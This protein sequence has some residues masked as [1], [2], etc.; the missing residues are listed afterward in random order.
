ATR[1]EGK[2]ELAHVADDRTRNYYFRIRSTVDPQALRP[3]LEPKEQHALD[4]IELSAPPV[5]DAEIWG[6]WHERNLTRIKAQVAI[7][8][9]FSFRGEP[10]TGFHTALEY[11]N[12][13]VQL[14]SPRLDRGAE[15]LSASTVGLDFNNRIVQVTNGFSTTDPAVVTRAVGPKVAKVME[16]YQFRQPPKVRVNGIFPMDNTA[17]ADAHF[18]VDGGPFHWEKFNLSRLSGQ[19]HWVGEHL[20]LE[21]VQAGFYQGKLTGLARFDFS[22]ANGTDFKFD[23]VVE[24]ASLHFLIADLFTPTNNLE[25]LLKGHLSVTNANTRDLHSW[26]GQGGVN[27]HDGFIWGIPVFGIFSP[28]LDSIV[29]GLGKSRASEASAAFI[30]TNGVVRSDD[31]QITAPALRIQYKGTVDLDGGKVD[32]RVTAAP[33]P[34][35][36]LVGPV[37]TV[38]LWPVSKLFEY[39]ITGTLARP[40]EEQMFFISRLLLAPFQMPFHP[41][42][43]LKGLVSGG[44]PEISTS[45]NSIAP[46]KPAP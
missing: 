33:L 45:T 20:S 21:G 1:P 25:G 36:L 32:A 7:T 17:K 35:T 8:T 15:F 19:A 2:I 23:A 13:F 24:D 34:N 28:V 39:K 37:A 31:L 41:F 26:F 16:P 6:R 18:D 44:E 29:P 27:L 43:T 9:N 11:T 38:V 22:P 4:Y 40:K 12:L 42:R 14:T 5:V 3:L 46:L 10:A 30:I